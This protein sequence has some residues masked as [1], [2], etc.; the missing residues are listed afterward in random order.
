MKKFLFKNWQL[1][2]LAVVS[3]II[4]WLFVVGIENTVSLF[5]QELDIEIINIDETV[6][7]SSPLPQVKIYIK[8]D[9]E[10][11]KNLTVKDFTAQVDLENLTAGEYTLPV[12]VIS[13]NPQVSVIRT[14]PKEI[15]IKLSPRIEKEVDVVASYTGN[16]AVNHKVQSLKAEPE[17]VRI[18]ATQ[19]VLDKIDNVEAKFV[20]DGAE[21]ENTEQKVSVVIP[22]QFSVPH[23]TITINPAQIMVEA[24]IVADIKD[25]E[26]PI[27]V[28]FN[29]TTDS[30]GWRQKVTLNPST[31]KITGE[32]FGEIEFIETAPVDINKLVNL[33]DTVTV[34]LILPDEISLK[35]AEPVTTVSLKDST[36]QEK[37]VA[38][39]VTLTGRNTIYKVTK[40]LPLEFNVIISGPAS[41]LDEIENGD[42]VVEFNIDE[43]SG[44]GS[45]PIDETNIIVP[46]GVLLRSFN[47]KE[48]SIEAE[49]LATI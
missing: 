20:M 18:T 48:I 39:L 28:S 23:E 34:G 17:K 49:S 31:V 19:A 27:R 5:N 47:P 44:S 25:K 2:I 10:I 21:T 38:A 15:D 7:I 1:K 13:K 14:E 36:E 22:D 45:Y 16:P 42:I 26:V 12:N 29:G 8:T 6:G 41:V 40:Y 4:L 46:E 30:E 11:I 3:A 43:I 35:D 37:E 33:K 32:N 9:K 24:V